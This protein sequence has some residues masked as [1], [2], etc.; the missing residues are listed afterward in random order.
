[1]KHTRRAELLFDQHHRNFRRVLRPIGKNFCVSPGLRSWESAAGIAFFVP[2]MICVRLVLAA[3]ECYP[4]CPEPLT[5]AEH[6]Y[7]VPPRILIVR[8]QAPSYCCLRNRPPWGS[9]IPRIRRRTNPAKSVAVNP[10][11]RV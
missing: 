11:R 2:P 1:M 6:P 8:R 3:S 4:P 10:H 7:A 9:T 5:L